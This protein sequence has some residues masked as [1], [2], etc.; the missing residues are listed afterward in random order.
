MNLDPKQD[1]P[2]SKGHALNNYTKMLPIIIATG[3]LVELDKV[4]L[5]SIRKN[6]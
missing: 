3:F 4:I 2:D 5:K 6:R 1:L